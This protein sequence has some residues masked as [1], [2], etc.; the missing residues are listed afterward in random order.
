ME[1]PVLLVGT[2]HVVDLS[3]PLRRVLSGR[4]LD[5]IAVELDA[6]RGAAVLH[7][8]PN[9]PG[10]GGGGPIFLRLWAAM[11]KRLGDELGQ[12][13]GAEMRAAAQLAGEWKIPVFLI[14]D[15]I[16][17]TIARLLRSLTVKERVSLLVGALIGFVMPA[18]VVKE[19]IG[20]YQ[21]APSDLL[22]ELRVQLP[23]V[24]KVLLDDRNEH[25]ADRLAEIR[26]R[27]FGR[28]AAVVGDAHLPGL[29][30]ALG[31]RGVPT[32]R[33]PLGTLLATGP[34]AGAA[35]SPRSS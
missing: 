9:G 23:G 29:A 32:E 26:R 11:Q 14:D 30:A 20:N 3:A 7:P 21:E 15:P 8:D 13:A 5:G 10:R 16:R 33:I 31:R 24:T 17:E 25:M 19:Q 35:A 22:E 6:E 1:S 4:A 2:A 18:R 12:G 34:S 28:V 27:G